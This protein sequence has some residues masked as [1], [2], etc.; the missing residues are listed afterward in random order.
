[1]K[2]VFG[3]LLAVF[4]ANPSFFECWIGIDMTSMDMVRLVEHLRLID[5]ELAR[6][7]DADVSKMDKSWAAVM[8]Q[9]CAC[10]GL[11]WRTG[12]G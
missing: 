9:W 11:R 10:F 7:V 8:R 5:P 4:R 3:G 12:R 6:V 2:R 1:M